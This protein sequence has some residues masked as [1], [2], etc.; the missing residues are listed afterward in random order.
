MR[1][2]VCILAVSLVVSLCVTVVNAQEGLILY[3]SF[4]DE[5]REEIEDQSGNQNNGKIV[6]G[7][8]LV[9]GK[10]GKAIELDGADDSIEVPD[11]DSLDIGKSSFT[12][13]CWIKTENIGTFRRIISKGHNGWTTGYIFQL[14]KSG[15]VVVATCSK[16]TKNEG[17]YAASVKTVNDGEWHHLVGIM[18]REKNEYRIFIDA[19]KADIHFPL[20]ALPT[21]KGVGDLSNLNRLTIG[22]WEGNN[23]YIQGLID[24]LRIWSRALAD[25]EIEKV[26]NGTILSVDRR[27]KLA[28]IWAKLKSQ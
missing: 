15:H 17:S 22:K 18:D 2:I 28:I 14:Y 8:N 27:A 3:F 7:A 4:E 9:D 23:E 13:E 21:P 1:V 25:E 10:I 26:M 5:I 11:S 24:E 20:G 19:Q 16:N 12:M 6:G